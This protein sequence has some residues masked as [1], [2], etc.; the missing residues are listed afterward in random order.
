MN[1]FNYPYLG[2]GLGLRTD[3]YNDIL[4]IWPEVDWFEI[5]SEN[6]MDSDGKPRAVLEQVA[7]HYPVVMHGVSL[8]IGST[9]PLR[10]DYLSR[11]KHLADWVK[12]AWI[13]DHLCYTGINKQ[14]T[15]DLLPV[16]YTAEALTHIVDR[17]K[18]VQDYLG[19]A[20]LIEN[21]SSYLEFSD[22]TM[23][24]WEFLARMAEEADCALLLDVNNVYVS[25]Y[26]HRLDPYVY[27]D[28]LPMDRVVQ[29]HLAGHDNQGTHIIDTHDDYV[30]DE[31]WC[32]YRYI[33]EK[34]GAITT[35]VEWDAKIPAFNVVWDEVKKAKAIVESV[36]KQECDARATSVVIGGDRE[37]SSAKHRTALDYTGLLSVLHNTIVQGANDNGTLPAPESWIPAKKDFTPK[38]QLGVY[39]N[40]YRYRLFDIVSEDYEA[41]RAYLGDE[42]MNLVIR[43][44]IEATPSTYYNVGRYVLGLPD[45]IER[46]NYVAEE[47]KAYA[48]EIARVEAAM[49]KLFDA[50]NTTPLTQAD[51]EEMDPESFLNLRLALRKASALFL[52]H[53]DIN[54][55]I[56]SIHGL[57]YTQDEENSSDTQ[58]PLLVY[59]DNITVWRLPLDMEEYA[60]LLLLQEEG[61]LIGELMEQLRVLSSKSDEALIADWQRYFAR[62]L[63]HGVVSV[64]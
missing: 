7:T 37:Q 54:A 4:D 18:H 26:N 1:K 13:S 53:H 43:H 48:L 44:Y 20:I 52:L 27:L 60:M 55:Y 58:F 24:E 33:I 2:F 6:Y 45:F 22:S 62:W 59:R 57:E 34:H 12:P 15:H 8:S 38:A 17:I 39:V 29:I 16:P 46:T 56:K 41:L 35:M 40:G 32:L 14:N 23:P 30:V 11:L 9:D 64:K 36:K 61:L 5:I 51:L 50:P 31:V 19:R 47:N 28:A 21:P 25:S 3:H 42:V 63:E 49:S 10:M